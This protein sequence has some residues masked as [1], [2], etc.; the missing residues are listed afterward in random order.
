MEQQIEAIVYLSPFGSYLQS[1]LHSSAIPQPALVQDYMAWGPVWNT[2]KTSESVFLSPV[3]GLLGCI[4]N[5]IHGSSWA[6]N[7]GT[8]RCGYARMFWLLYPIPWSRRNGTIAYS[9]SI[10]APGTR[11]RFALRR[12]FE[13]MG[14]VWK[15]WLLRNLVVGRIYVPRNIRESRWYDIRQPGRPSHNGVVN[16]PRLVVY[17]DC[18]YLLAIVAGDESSSLSRTR[19]RLGVNKNTKSLRRDVWLASLGRAK[20][21]MV[22]LL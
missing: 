9:L 21:S 3:P 15:W 4:V 22:L 14:L 16:K 6:A 10:K 5:R 11:A 19:L 17:L 8:D 7:T 13:R 20:S 12:S 18:F 1:D 2:T